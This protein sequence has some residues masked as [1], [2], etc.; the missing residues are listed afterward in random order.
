MKINQINQNQSFKAVY[1]R[2]NLTKDW[3]QVTDIGFNSVHTNRFLD[4]MENA[5]D[6]INLFLSST[7]AHIKLKNGDTLMVEGRIDRMPVVLTDKDAKDF[8]ELKQPSKHFTEDGYR[9]NF[10]SKALKSKFDFNT[11]NFTVDEVVE[12]I[13]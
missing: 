7:H 9:F 10:I 13:K 11:Q 2:P 4:A 1:V 8:R 12:A 6:K 5:K 3:E